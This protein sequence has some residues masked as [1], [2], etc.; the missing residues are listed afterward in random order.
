M[1]KRPNKRTQKAQSIIQLALFAGIVILV[2]ILANARIGGR[3]LYT[4]LDLT[5]EKRYTLTPATRNLLQEV[6]DV[7]YVQVLL[8]GDFPAGYKRLQAAVTDMLEDFRSESGYVEFAFED[9]LAGTADQINARKEALAKDGIIPVNLQVM[10]SG[11]R[12][13][14]LTY[15]YAIFN[16]KGRRQA[17][18]FLENQI[19]GVPP[20]LILNNS[21]ALLEYKFA[22]AIQQLRSPEKPAVVF[23]AGHGELTPLET[24]DWENTMRE[25]YNTGRL[26]LDSVP[27]ISP[28]IKVLV[29]A[30]PRIPFSERDKFKIDQYVMQGGKLLWLLDMV[31]VELD[32]LRRGEYLP[33]DYNLALDELLFRYGIRIQ[34][35]LVLDMQCTQIPLATGVVGNAPQFEYFRYPYHIVTI[36][37]SDQLIV[38]SL[39][40]VNLLYASSI[41]TTVRTRQPLQKTV[42]LT[43]S[44]T[45]RLQYLPLRMNFD[46]LR[47][48]L[49]ASKFDAGPQPLALLVE[50]SFTSL[51]ENRV[52]ESM[53]EG[54]RALNLTFQSASPAN[55]MIVVADGDIARNR[56]D[57]KTQRVAPLGYNEFERYRFANKEFLMNAVAYLLDGSGLIA[58]RGKEVKLRL[59]NRTKV[60]AE[61]TQWQLINLLIPLVFLG[62]FGLGYQFWRRRRYGR[63]V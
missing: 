6:D 37:R 44:E 51:Y 5:E 25:S 33:G 17:V 56:F 4:Y 29:V 23:T 47:Y 9:P 57:P 36:P 45:S 11:E 39:G 31:N 59:L 38:K 48:D 30:K 42:L 14:K 7:V 49:D 21:I 54:L 28:E 58:A 15:P 13:E 3:A 50:G 35:N 20:D 19:P 46:F 2:N 22:E 55:K 62:L 18:N 27:A 32:S 34:P 53:Q 12:S 63:T 43:S 10:E 1:T 24:G 41:D 40:P 52:T 60:K 61:R 16:Y 26:V 8:Q